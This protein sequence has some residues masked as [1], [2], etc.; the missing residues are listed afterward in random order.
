MEE[1]EREVPLLEQDFA[2]VL[3]EYGIGLK[4]DRYKTIAKHISRVGGPNVYED[5]ENLSQRLVE[6]SAEIDPVKRRLI[7]ERWSS[8]KNLPVSE[9]MLKR[10]EM[11]DK[12]REKIVAEERRQEEG[13]VWWVEADEK[14]MP[15]LR[16]I[17][18]EE[19]G[20]TLDEAK[21]AMKAMR[22]DA[23]S[24]EGA[25]QIIKYDTEADRHIPNWES[26]WVR[27]NPAAAWATARNLDLAKAAGEERDPVEIFTEQMARIE[28]FKEVAGV[29]REAERA[30][31]TELIDGLEKLDQIRGRK[32]GGLPEWLSA[33]DKLDEMIQRRMPKT[34]G[35]NEEVK[36]LREQMQKQAEK[37][38]EL[39]ESLR[40]KELQ[41]LK[42]SFNQTVKALTTKI[43]DLEKKPQVSTG[44]T[45]ADI[46]FEFGQR[47]LDKVP[48][49][50]DIREVVGDLM[51]KGPGLTIRTPEQREQEL[52]QIEGTIEDMRALRNFEDWW[53]WG[54]E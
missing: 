51:R 39:K 24:A 46:V 28:S 20:M 13:R 3:M 14:G 11:P 54:G 26:A 2:Q 36:A 4:N 32:E 10:A 23:L 8:E 47:V 49:K 43:E 48:D 19:V 6:W 21:E 25:E 31:I 17:K 30:S 53:I 27:Q 16:P 41:D 35:E 37:M 44:R 9:E 1:H 52:G 42:D 38:E 45:E 22:T 50:Q 15:H 33:M 40:A 29:K 18:G 34:T 7:L 12:K 5:L